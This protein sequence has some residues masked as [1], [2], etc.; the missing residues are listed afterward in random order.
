M[1][2]KRCGRRGFTLIELLVVIAIIAVLIA[3][4]LPAV[5]QA[6]EAARR[7][8][9]KN[10]LKQM[11]LAIHNY[12][13]TYRRIP[14]GFVIDSQNNVPCYGWAPALLPFMDQGGLYDALFATNRALKQ[15][16]NA[17]S[18]DADKKLLQTSIPAF[19]CPSDVTG[20][21]N[22]LEVFGNTNYFDIATSNYVAY[23]GY[24]PSTTTLNPTGRGAFYGN[25]Y[26]S[27]RD[28]PE[29]LTNV[30]FLSERDG[31]IAGG[32]TATFKAAVWA[33]V[34][35]R[36]SNGA[37]AVARCLARA[38][39]PIN[40]DYVAAGSTADNLGKGVGSM[41]EGGV[42]AALGDGSVRFLSEN[43]SVAGVY[44]PLILRDDGV[45]V[46]DF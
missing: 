2:V 21:L 30:L 38:G 14:A 5:Q 27:L 36:N 24:D 9:C 4:L 3:L 44:T 41:H 31:G 46:G 11:A 19:R 6:R 16:Y 33:G 35:R 10:N 1:V 15:L 8:Q 32:G 7:S 12:E 45:V 40:H 25:S 23:C 13:S 29:G 43:I 20:N 26:L 22:D 17:T 42:H 28:F 37:S 18:T 34:G 39:F